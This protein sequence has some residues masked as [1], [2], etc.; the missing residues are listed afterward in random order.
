MIPLLTA[1]G[2]RPDGES[3]LSLS[4]FSEDWQGVIDTYGAFAN[5][6][7][8]VINSLVRTSAREVPICLRVRANHGKFCLRGTI[9]SA[10]FRFELG[11]E[12][13]F[14]IRLEDGD[15]VDIKLYFSSE[16]QSTAAHTSSLAAV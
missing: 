14:R 16:E 5:Q 15:F 8:T 11:K 2:G 7:A 4:A 13:A 6:F 3:V 9:V 1:A 10:G 12:A